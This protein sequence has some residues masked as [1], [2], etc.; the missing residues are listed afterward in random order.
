MIY[1]LIGGLALAGAFDFAQRPSGSNG[2]MAKLVHVPLGHLI[3]ALLALGL[4]AFVLWQL[5]LAVLDPEC[6]EGRWSIKR[7]A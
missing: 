5:V 1:L 7:L 4:A 2:A 6:H 3:L